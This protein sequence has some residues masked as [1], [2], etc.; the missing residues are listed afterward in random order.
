MTEREVYERLRVLAALNKNSTTE[1]EE[2]AKEVHKMTLAAV[3][4]FKEEIRVGLRGG[5]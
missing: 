1:V 3:E 2:L 5:K 4:A